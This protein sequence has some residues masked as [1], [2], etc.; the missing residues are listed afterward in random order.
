ML[1]REPATGHLFVRHEAGRVSHIELSVF[2]SPANRN[3]EHQALR[4]LI[5]TL[6][7]PS[8]GKA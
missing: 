7:S 6:I 5:S 3:P 8:H 2:L 4:D 1:A